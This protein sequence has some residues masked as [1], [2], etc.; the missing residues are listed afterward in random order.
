[1]ERLLRQALPDLSAAEHARLASLAEGSPGRA[2]QLAE[3]NGIALS[4]TARQILGALPAFDPGA[5]LDLA[6]KLA[7]TDGQYSY[8][9]DLL[10]HNLAAEVRGAARG[11]PSLIAHLRSPDEWVE[12]WQALTRLQEATE[13]LNLDKKQALIQALTL[14]STK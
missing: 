1:M 5:A 7:A 11:E 13:E 4:D 10:R 8:F 12:C 9:M 2:I 6:D 14:L 3:G